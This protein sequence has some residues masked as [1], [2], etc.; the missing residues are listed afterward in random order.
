[1]SEKGA[2]II[3]AIRE[4]AAESPDFVYKG[5]CQYVV[6]GQPGCLVGHA[7][8]RLGLIDEGIERYNTN[9]LKIKAFDLAWAFD[10]AELAWLGHVQNRQDRGAPWGVAVKDADEVVWPIYAT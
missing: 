1:M 10:R 8:W 3:A 6:N 2:A 7:L 5:M 4:V 9:D